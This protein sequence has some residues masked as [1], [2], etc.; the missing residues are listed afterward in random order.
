MARQYAG[1]GGWVLE[2]AAGEG[3]ITLPLAREGFRVTALDSSPAMLARLREKLEAEPQDVRERVQTAESDM[4]RFHLDRLFRLVCLPF[5]TFLLLTE[6]HDR[7]ALLQSVREHLAPS[8]AFAFDIFTPDPRRLVDSPDWAV[9]LEHESA[10]PWGAGQ[11]HVL[12]EMRR[13]QNYGRQVSHV[14]FRHT[15]SQSGEVLA[16]WE[17]DLDFGIIYPRELEL[18]LEREGFRI[19]DRFG[20]PDRRPYRPTAGDMHSQ[21]VVAELVP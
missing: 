9:E 12:R 4:R 20:G 2:L 21:Y 19:R 18:I 17:D 3:R 8:G 6:T 11:V 13:R 1:P 5:N 15:I 14:D 10:D 7:E 16:R